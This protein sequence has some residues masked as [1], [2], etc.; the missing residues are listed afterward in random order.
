MN[1]FGVGANGVAGVPDAGSIVPGAGAA[2]GDSSAFSQMLD[3]LSD[4][5]GLADQAV[6]DVASGADVDLH[7]V[8]LAVEMESLA[9]DLAVVDLVA[10]MR[11]F[12]TVAAP[13]PGDPYDHNEFR[14]HYS[15]HHPV[16]FRVNV[17]AVDDD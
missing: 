4:A 3:G 16:V 17:P 11:P 8:T 12:W 9:F 10:A 13:Y 5:S 2:A 7:D 14:K 6:T 1:V 15:D